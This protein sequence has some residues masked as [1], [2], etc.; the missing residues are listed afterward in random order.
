MCSVT[1]V[2]HL[3]QSPF[4]MCAVT[5]VGISTRKSD[6]NSYVENITRA[7]GA[8][9]KSP[10]RV[11]STWEL[12]QTSRHQPVKSSCKNRP[13]GALQLRLR[14]YRERPLMVFVLCC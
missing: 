7:Q 13:G 2:E 11:E 1:Y 6:F 8:H 14:Q 3:T 10:K 5:Y 12:G 9:L 4:K